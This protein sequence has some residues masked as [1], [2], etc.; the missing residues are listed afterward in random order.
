[1]FEDSKQLGIARRRDPRSFFLAWYS[2]QLEDEEKIFGDDPCP[3]NL[4]DNLTTLEAML[5]Y[6]AEQAITSRRMKID[7]IFF[8]T[9][10]SL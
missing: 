6:A 1:M 7:E 2:A 4:K 10:L 9:T 3:Y 5:D 8:P